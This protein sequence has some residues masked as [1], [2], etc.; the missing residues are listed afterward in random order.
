MMFSHK[1]NSTTKA[2]HKFITLERIIKNGFINFGRNIWLAVAAIAM[3]AITLTILLFAVV[4]NATFAHSITDF[5]SRINVSVYLKDSVLDKQKDELISQLR[6]IDNVQTVT[7]VS[8]DQALKIYKEQ[9]TNKPLLLNIISETGNTL[10]ASLKISPKDPNQLQTIKDFLDKP[11]IG[12]LQSDPTS[13]SGDLKLAIDKIAKATH[14]FKQAGVV[15]IIVFIIISMLIIFNTIRMAIFNRRE[16]LI[17]MRLLGAKPG[18]IRGPFVVENIIYGVVAAAISLAVCAALFKIAS[19]TLQAST[20]GLLDIK[21][22]N[23]Y[24]TKNLW[25]ILA[26]QTGAG[27]IIGATF[28]AIATRRYLRLR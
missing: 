1:K 19:S 14:F 6:A 18:Y 10:P 15:G 21:Y 23:D 11:E 27:I 5:T 25:L 24:F 2:D 12:K 7:Y 16:E 22:A 3:M 20:F 26:V 17:I 28:S 8:K 9:S 4:A 13:Y